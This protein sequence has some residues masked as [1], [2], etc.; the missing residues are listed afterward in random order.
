IEERASRHVYK[1]SKT[2]K[3]IQGPENSGHGNDLS[4][5]EHCQSQKPYHHNRSKNS[6]KTMGAFVLKSKKQ[7]QNDEGNNNDIGSKGMIGKNQSFNGSQYRDCWCHYS[8][9]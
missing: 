3:R 8:F 2:I 4:Q 7:S 1:Q 5:T 9:A 6:A